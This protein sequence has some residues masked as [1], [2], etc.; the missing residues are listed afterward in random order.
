M[1]I[2]FNQNPR[3]AQDDL[4]DMPAEL[5]Q[6]MERVSKSRRDFMKVTGMAAMGAVLAGCTAPDRLVKPLLKKQEHIMP[7]VAYDYAST[8]QACS[9]N[10]GTWMKARDGRPIKAEGARDNPLNRGG[11]CARGQGQLWGL[12]DSERLKG[13]LQKSSPVKWEELDAAV[14]GAVKGGGAVLLTGTVNGACAR[15]QIRRFC[16]ATGARHVAYDAISAWP[17]AAAHKDTHG[18]AVLPRYRFELAEVVVAIEADFLGSWISPVEYAAGWAVNRDLRNGR[19]TLS[20]HFQLEA[21]YTISGANADERIKLP[22]AE[23]GALLTALANKLA[24]NTRF[25]TA[26]AHSVPPEKLDDIVKAIKDAPRKALVVCGSDDVKHQKLVNAIN[27][28]A[29]AYGNTVDLRNVSQQKLGNDD[30][31]AQLLKDLESGAVKTLIVWGANPV[32]ELPEG[33]KFKELL[34]KVGT[35]VAISAFPDETTTE[36]NW[37]ASADHALESWGDFEPVRGLHSLSQP[38][39]RRLYDTRNPLTSL[40][41]WAGHADGNRDYREVLADYWKANVLQGGA[42]EA[43]VERGFVDAQGSVV[44]NMPVMN[45]GA[46]TGLNAGA[47]ATGD[48]LEIVPYQSVLMGDGSQANNGWLH[49]AGD[50][51]TRATWGNYVALNPLTMKELGIADGDDVTLSAEAE[52]RKVELKL[53]AV[54][55]PGLAGK[56]AAVALGFGRTQAGK[57]V[58]GMGTGALTGAEATIGANAYPLL[59]RGKVVFG[60]VAKSGGNRKPARIQEHDSQEK[61]PLLKETTLEQWLG[62]P[63][64][65]NDQ[66]LPPANLTLWPRWEYNGHKWGLVVDL[67]SCTGCS[68]CVV[69][70]SVENNVPVV[71]RE[72]VATRREMHWLRMDV[73]YEDDHKDGLLTENENPLAGFQPMMCQHCENAPCE[74]VCPVIATSHTEEGLNSMTYNRCIGTRYCANNCPYKVRRFNWFLY[75]HNDLTMNL[76]L[77]PDVTVRTQGVMEKCS[78]CAQRIY[79]GK[80]NAARAGVKLPDGAIRTACQSSCPTN[81]IAFGDVNDKDSVVTRLLKDPRNYAV[82]AEINTRPAVTYLT[83]VR[84]RKAPPAPA[85]GHGGGH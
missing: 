8:C 4:A 73:Y 80:R 76:A 60:T 47:L 10:C 42:W 83:K 65:G 23:R 20:K 85:D 9:A 64:A 72:E 62:K 16:E 61:R 3:P 55:Q 32:Y 14:S 70:C 22:A 38:L 1:Q 17:I 2:E 82:L 34:A 59:A 75:K 31:L 53:P 54:R 12:Y 33:A 15:E 50:P 52:G 58:Y 40:L 37:R 67:N 35:T 43:A 7:G 77:N 48:G 21:N 57:I 69:A 49:E 66:H 24:G 71:G 84:N 46:A 68:A 63:D 30:T 29:Q 56:S 51:L 11:L 44:T 45:E 78:M 19:R 39:V 25:G 79:E 27:H 28:M 74:T 36:C 5:R 81:A 18:A 26:G 6:E 13:P 41:K